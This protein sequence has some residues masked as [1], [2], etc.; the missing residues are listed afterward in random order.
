MNFKKIIL[1]SLS[2]L[3]I[4]KA[5]GQTKHSKQ[6]LYPTY[7]GLVMAGYQGWFRAEGDGTDSKRYAYGDEKRSSIDMWPDV[8]EYEVTYNTPFKLSSGQ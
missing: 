3:F 5:Q 7:K 6:T 1:L 2:C 4:Y 8:S